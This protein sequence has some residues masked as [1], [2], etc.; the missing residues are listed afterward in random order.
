MDTLF[1]K[2]ADVINRLTRRERKWRPLAMRSRAGRCFARARKT[3]HSAPRATGCYTVHSRKSRSGPERIGG[4]AEQPEVAMVWRYPAQVRGDRPARP[5]EYRDCTT[6]DYRE[7]AELAGLGERAD[8]SLVSG[9]CELN[10][11]VGFEQW[12]G[13]G[14]SLGAPG[15]RR[16]PACGARTS[17]K[18]TAAPDRRM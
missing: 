10:Q 12:S 16:G 6:S 5:I 11:P 18:H 2:N 9:T 4:A 17:P 13:A 8:C 7:D 3:V 1:K 15:L 14:M